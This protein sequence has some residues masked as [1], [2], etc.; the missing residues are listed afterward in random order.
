MTM[1]DGS[2]QNKKKKS[3]NQKKKSYLVGANLFL[4]FGITE[5]AGA[6]SRLCGNTCKLNG[7]THRGKVPIFWLTGV[8]LV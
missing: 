3:K 7:M 4:C 5:V 6:C 1:H 8:I 2:I